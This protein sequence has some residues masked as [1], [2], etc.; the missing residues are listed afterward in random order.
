MDNYIFAHHIQLLLLLQELIEKYG[1]GE[2]TTEQAAAKCGL[3]LPTVPPHQE[4][5]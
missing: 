2:L 1:K 4:P 3:A 5:N